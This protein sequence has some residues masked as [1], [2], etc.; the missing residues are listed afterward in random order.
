MTCPRCSACTDPEHC[1]PAYGMG[2]CHDP[3]DPDCNCDR[4]LPDDESA[5]LDDLADLQAELD[6]LE[7]TDPKVAAAAASYDAMVAKVTGRL[8]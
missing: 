8:R 6:D 5:D 7:A 2:C 4:C 3:D 1:S